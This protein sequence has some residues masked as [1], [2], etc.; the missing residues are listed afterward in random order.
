VS[1]YR[2]ARSPYRRSESQLREREIDRAY[3][4]YQ[5]N[6]PYEEVHVPSTRLASPSRGTPSIAPPTNPSAELRGHSSDP[7][8]HPPLLISSEVRFETADLQV[9]ESYQ[10][11]VFSDSTASLSGMTSTAKY[12][13]RSKTCRSSSGMNFFQIL[14]I[15]SGASGR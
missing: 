9:L 14:L 5:S 2:K 1:W 3:S 10:N 12:A 6:D 7:D 15:S 11:N 8:I 4:N 13:P